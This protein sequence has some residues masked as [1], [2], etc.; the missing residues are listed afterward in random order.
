VQYL[1]KILRMNLKETGKKI[2]LQGLESCQPP[3]VS[4]LG[5]ITEFE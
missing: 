4:A 5:F 1:I 2:S 3:L